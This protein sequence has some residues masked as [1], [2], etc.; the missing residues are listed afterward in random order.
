M[1]RT[2]AGLLIVFAVG[3]PVSSLTQQP[4]T[5]RPLDKGA[6]VSVRGCVHG[7]ML[8]PIRID[9]GTVSGAV[10]GSNHYRL[11]GSKEI[12]SQLKKANGKLVD[13]TGHLRVEDNRSMVNSKKSGKAT[14]TIG[15]AQGAQSTVLDNPLEDGT[16]D[17]ISVEVVETACNSK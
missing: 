10:T 13:V 14:I 5:D 3:A 1:A 4:E 6:V 16:I 2:L 9:P 7:S 17:A 11:V 12:R 15:T 8:T